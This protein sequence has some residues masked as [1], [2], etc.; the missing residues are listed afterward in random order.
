MKK[1]HA[2]WILLLAPVLIFL[3]CEH[4]RMEDPYAGTYTVRLRFNHKV[5]N[6]PFAL[7]TNYQNA[8][9]ETYRLHTFKYYISNIELFRDGRSVGAVDKDGYHLITAADPANETFTFQVSTTRLTSL[10]FL[11]GVDSIR[12]VS[13][14]QTGALDPFNGMFWTWST[15][16]IMAKMEGTS[17]ASAQA[18][19]DIIYHIGGFKNP[20]NNTRWLNL[21][22]PNGKEVNTRNNGTSEILIDCDINSWFKSRHDMKIADVSFTMS[23]GA[24]ASKFADNYSTLFYI[25]DVRNN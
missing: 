21:S 1:K 4:E 14:A 5:G 16:Y 17:P 6:A 22:F 7:N 2:L 15:G 8:F 12:N 11:I 25:T 20:N 24:L 3:G 9:G 18:G 10:R 13:G 23:L 19:N